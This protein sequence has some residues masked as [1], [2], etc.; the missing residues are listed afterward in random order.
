[1]LN[2]LQSG[3]SMVK[4]IGFSL[5]G[6]LCALAGVLCALARHSLWMSR[7]ILAL[8]RFVLWCQRLR[9][10][11]SW[12][13]FKQDSKGSSDHQTVTKRI[14]FAARS[15]DLWRLLLCISM[16]WILECDSYGKLKCQLVLARCW[17]LMNLSMFWVDE[18]LAI[19]WK[20]L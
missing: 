1:M 11:T 13:V 15:L 14:H 20:T 3:Y 7:R 16:A 12:Q 9:L 18:A 6:V 8:Q 2:D 17:T 5:A 19:N 4:H 10:A